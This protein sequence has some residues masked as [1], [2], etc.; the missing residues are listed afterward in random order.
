MLTTTA[1]HHPLAL[2][3][4]RSGLTAGAYLHK[5]A[6]RHRALGFGTMA[7]RREKAT[8]WTRDGVTPDRTTL[9]A[10]ASLHHIRPADVHRYGWPDFLRL[11]LDD[12][13]PYLESPWTAAGTVTLLT[14]VG[15]PV[16]RRGFLIASSSTLAAA[17]AQWTTAEPALATTGRHRRV[18]HE[19]ANLFDTRLNALRRLD[20]EVGAHH[21]YDAAL[22]EIRLITDLL[23]HAYYTENI[24]RRLFSAAAEAARIAGW[25]AYD[26]GHHHTAERHF[27]TSLRATASAGDTTRGAITLAFW[28]N[29]RYSTG[30]PQGALHLIDG[31]LATRHTIHSPR[32][33][34]LL[35]ARAARAHSTA[36]DHR[37]A[38]QQIDAAFTA[39][40]HADTP[41]ADI[42]SLYWI[43]HGELHQV[44]A[45]TALTLKT[46]KKALTHFDAA[47]THHDPYDLER[48]LRGTVIYQGRRTEAH[49][50]LGDI[51]AALDTGHQILTT[52]DGID[53]ARSTAALHQVRD[54]LNPHQHI[55]AV[56][57]FLQLSA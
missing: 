24:G 6:E 51:D 46:P 48:E 49:I 10:I 44:A 8:R 50:A 47:F 40:A 17:V 30:D 55:P 21:V 1:H 42:S 9:L 35:H 57:D 56:A 54:H 39:Y 13:R 29:L 11:A 15:G 34:A 20:D 38:W 43:T 31:A 32:A 37:N 26:T 25:C 14:E 5:V 4:A 12:D 53:S 36:G 19:A 23:N 27:I 28:S 52:I 7:C 18:G 2:L 33:L 41:E 45:S 16:D 3:I 22:V